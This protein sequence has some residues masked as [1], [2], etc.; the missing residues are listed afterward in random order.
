MT[1]Q[2]EEIGAEWDGEWDALAGQ[3]PESGFMQSSAWMAFKRLEGYE[4][5]RYGLFEG[6]RLTGGGAFLYYPAQS[7]KSFIVCP[8]GPLLAWGE[9]ERARQGLR[10]LIGAAKEIADRQGALGLRIEPRLAK[11]KPSVLRNWSRAP[12]DLIPCQTLFLD[13]TLSEEGFLAQMQPKGRYNLRL[14]A[15]HGVQIR[16]SQEMGDLSR[17]YALFSETASRN[18]FFAEPYGFFLNLGATLFP[19]EMAGLL[20]AEREGE[21][22]AA[23]LT[24]FFGRRATFLYGG[25]SGLNR[26]YMPSYPLH[27]EALRLAQERGCVEYDMY[28]YEPFGVKEHLYAGISRFKRQFGGT[29]AETIGAQDLLFYDRLA[30]ALVERLQGR[31]S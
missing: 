25:S 7:G 18:E 15:R 17:F 30:D 24:L 28:G 22:L 20:F 26:Q 16:F 10:L 29:Y 1:Y 13:A 5:V 4:T 3:S 8:E 21:T 12:V 14:A 11:P 31:D 6:E 23:I 27:R 19:L 2:L 9:T